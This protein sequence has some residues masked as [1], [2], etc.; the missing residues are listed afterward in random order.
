MLLEV[1]W[2]LRI[3]FIVLVFSSDDSFQIVSIASYIF[4]VLL[5]YIKNIAVITSKM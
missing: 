1:N 4:T 5:N 3:D 2:H